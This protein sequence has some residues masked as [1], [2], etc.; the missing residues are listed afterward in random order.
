MHICNNGNIRIAIPPP[1]WFI[2]ICLFI[3]NYYKSRVMLV[4]FLVREYV[5]DTLFPLRGGDCRSPPDVVRLIG[6]CLFIF[7]VYKSRFKARCFWR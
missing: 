3:F 4:L 7:N 2:G 1:D 5:S 6:I